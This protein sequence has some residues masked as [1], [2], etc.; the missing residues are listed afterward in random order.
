ML[1]EELVNLVE[2]ILIEKIEGQ[3]IEIKSSNKGFPKIWGTL[4]AFAN[5][6][7]GGIIKF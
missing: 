5:Q 3:N 7:S 4:S 2:K 1:K 6:S